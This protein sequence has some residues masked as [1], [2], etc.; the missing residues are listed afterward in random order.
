M[1]EKQVK[2]ANHIKLWL[3]YFLQGCYHSSTI[4]PTTKSPISTASQSLSQHCIIT[5]I[6]LCSKILYMYV[7]TMFTNMFSAHTHT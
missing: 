5:D 1:R 3:L 4:K 7:S 2:I 6:E